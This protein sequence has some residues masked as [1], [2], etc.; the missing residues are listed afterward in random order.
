MAVRKGF[1]LTLALAGLAVFVPTASAA[2]HQ[3]KVREVHEGGATEADYVELQMYQS[4]QNFVSGHSV[5]TYDGGGNEFVTFTFPSSVANDQN[6][7]TILL[8]ST[9]ALAVT[10]D[11]TAPTAN[12]IPGPNSSVCFIDTL[13]SNGID[14]VSFGTAAPPTTN[15]SPV[16]T[17]A[18]PLGDGQ[19]LERTIG[20]D[21]STLLEAS[22]DNNDSATDFALAT[23]SPRNNSTA[24]TETT[25]GGGGGGGGDDD[26]AAPQTKITKKPD[27]RTEKT[28]AKFAFNSNEAGSTFKCK[29]D[30]RKFKRCKS[31][32]KYK[33]LDPGK[34]KFKVKATD[35][36]G[37]T[38]RTPAKVSFKVVE[39]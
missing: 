39:D 29:L 22:D 25:C 4:G 18:A 7:R 37:N 32:K 12:L 17:P 1:A 26:A 30:K 14:C 10:P 35:A 33:N 19:S 31:P 8:A 16:G 36:A 38:D 2:Y 5:V 13:P 24:P 21:C 34:H 15:P 27:A 9:G 3:M 28:T 20:F 11:F 6:Q 23:P